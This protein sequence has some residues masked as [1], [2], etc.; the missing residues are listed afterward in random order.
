MSNQDFDGLAS[1][2]FNDPAI[3]D[4][5]WLDEGGFASAPIFGGGV[6]YKFNDYLRGDLTVE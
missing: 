2:L 4:F 6:G 3:T 1:N 5:G